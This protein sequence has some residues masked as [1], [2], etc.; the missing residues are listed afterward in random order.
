MNSQSITNQ[1]FVE[2]IN[3]KDNKIEELLLEINVQEEL[4]EDNERL[5]KKLAD[6]QD[7][8]YRDSESYLD[9]IKIL[10]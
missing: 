4:R 1:E 2:M 3:Q 5:K 7:S 10:E 9:K 6:V 8:F